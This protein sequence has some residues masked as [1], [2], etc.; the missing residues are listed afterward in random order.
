MI[1]IQTRVKWTPK[2]LK[3]RPEWDKAAMKRA[4]PYIRLMQHVL[5]LV[6]ERVIV[7]REHAGRGKFRKYKDAKKKHFIYWVS[8]DRKQPTAGIIARRRV[9]SEEWAGYASGRSYKKQVSGS[10]HKNFVETGAMWNSLRI[11]LRSHYS[12]RAA[13]YG[14]S[15]DR[16]LKGSRKT[17]NADKAFY[18]TKNEK[19]GENGARDLKG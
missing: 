9:G 1:D 8:P 7:R 14:S 17:R 5:A 2:K 10:E 15:H 18:G 3:D 6:K 4:L 13:F 12:M 11:R 16:G 19:Y